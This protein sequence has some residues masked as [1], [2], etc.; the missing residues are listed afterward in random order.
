MPNSK[1]RPS[2]SMSIFEHLFGFG[3]LR[4]VAIQLRPWHLSHAERERDL[5][6]WTRQQVHPR[7][8]G[9]DVSCH[10]DIYASPRQLLLYR[11]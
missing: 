4:P 10:P 7:T 5:A 6:T 8:A 11:S 9:I 2:R 3:P 1:L